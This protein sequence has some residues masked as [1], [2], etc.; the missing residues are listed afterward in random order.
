MDATLKCEKK[1]T[2]KIVALMNCTLPLCKEFF[3]EIT[4]YLDHDDFKL[5]ITGNQPSITLP[6]YLDKNA[7]SVELII[8]KSTF[9]S[10]FQEAHTYFNSSLSDQSMF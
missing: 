1:T 9:L 10:L 5:T 8:F 2:R 3:K 6:Y 7:H 4:A